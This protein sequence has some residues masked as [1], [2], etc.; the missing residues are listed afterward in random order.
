MTK[1]YPALRAPVRT[2]EFR[3][4]ALSGASSPVDTRVRNASFKEGGALPGVDRG[5]ARLLVLVPGLAERVPGREVAP[6]LSG[7]GVD[8]DDVLGVAQLEAQQSLGRALVLGQG[9]AHGQHGEAAGEE[10]EERLLHGAS[11]PE[12]RANGI[13]CECGTSVRVAFGWRGFGF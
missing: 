10:G 13:P 9:G 4:E 8:H 2:P 11:M 5:P 7:L 3:Q 6:D 12:R 1:T